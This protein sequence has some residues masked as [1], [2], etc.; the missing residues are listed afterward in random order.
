MGKYLVPL[1]ALLMPA[2]AGAGDAA[3]PRLFTEEGV[4]GTLVIASLNSGRT[5]VHNDAR[6]RQRFSPASTFKILHTLIAIEEQAVA[7]E[8]AV[9]KWD[10]HHYDVP[11]WNQDQTLASAF[12]V[13]CVW[14]YQ[15]LARRVG[16]KS[17]PRYLRQSGYGALREDFAPTQFWLDGSLLISALEQIGFLKKVVTRSLP[18]S[19][20]AY[21]TLKK[22]MLAE[23]TPVYSLWA[24]T[25]WTPMVTP[26]VGWYVGYVQTSDDIWLFALN[27]EIRNEKD[28]PRRQGLVRKALR[29][30]AITVMDPARESENGD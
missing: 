18:F 29:S 28:L 21:G 30:K 19:E 10:G 24:K 22:I 17:Y 23:Q 15:E 8:N 9:F 5:F 3:I 6:A 11:A 27:M 26:Q 20:A 2:F 4:K 13:S 12:K 1:V 16:A 25:G 14:C 7:D